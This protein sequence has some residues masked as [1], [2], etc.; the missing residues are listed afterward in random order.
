MINAHRGFTLLELLLAMALFAIVSLLGWRGLD[1]IL[2]SRPAVEAQSRAALELAAAWTQL[3][4]DLQAAR[5]VHGL[6]RPA[7]AISAPH[8]VAH[9]N[10]L[11]LLRNPADCP[12]CWEGVHY[13]ISASA[14]LTRASTGAQPTAERALAALNALAGNEA[15]PAT[16]ATQA[17]RATQHTLLTGVDGMRVAVWREAGEGAGGWASPN[18]AAPATRGR[19]AYKVEWRL[20]APWE[21]WVSRSLL[22]DNR[23]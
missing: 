17:T 16:Q 4:T 14:A 13:A 5:G 6:G 15:S 1:S 11:S 19:Q 23:W 18:G 8:I 22:V 10:S 3:E 9:P 21:G 12:G 7:N 2:A 20:A